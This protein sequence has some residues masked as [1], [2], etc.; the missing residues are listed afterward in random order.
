[1]ARPCT[2]GVRGV[3]TAG[4]V[5]VPW[6]RALVAVPGTEPRKGCS[7][8]GPPAYKLRELGRR[9]VLGRAGNGEP[10]GRRPERRDENIADPWHLTS[11]KS[12]RLRLQSWGHGGQLPPG[13]EMRSGQT[14][15]RPVGAIRGILHCLTGRRAF[16][17][18]PPSPPLR[19]GA[20][21][22][23]SESGRSGSTA[24]LHAM[25]RKIRP[26]RLIEVGETTGRSF[27]GQGPAGSWVSSLAWAR[28][29]A[30]A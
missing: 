15:R 3:N 18:S 30:C 8:G 16:G 7:I 26:E 1:M 29:A 6:M 2:S 27:R 17:C 25:L 20:L 11:P 9:A 14:S 23:S 4:T 22:K 28:P 21:P 5:I 24:A 13:W 10:L 19:R 12:A